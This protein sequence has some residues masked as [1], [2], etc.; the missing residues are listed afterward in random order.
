MTQSV[1]VLKAAS[2]PCFVQRRAATSNKKINID[3]LARPKRS[4]PLALEDAVS[5]NY[6][7]RN[8]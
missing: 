7:N 8:K 1:G 4:L 6:E 2:G 3:Q 5:Q